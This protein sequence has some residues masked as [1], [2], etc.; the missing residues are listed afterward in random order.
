MHHTR[1]KETVGHCEPGNEFCS[2]CAN[3][4]L[5]ICL[6]AKLGSETVIEER[7]APVKLCG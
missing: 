5:D 6:L 1:L 2:T 4:T 7:F 3:D